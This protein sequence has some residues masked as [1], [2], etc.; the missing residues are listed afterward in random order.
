MQIIDIV[1]SPHTQTKDIDFDDVYLQLN[2][3]MVISKR[4]GCQI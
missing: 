2:V 1:E 4:L 3:S